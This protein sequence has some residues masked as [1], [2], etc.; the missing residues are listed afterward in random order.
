M[1]VNTRSLD[2]G[3]PDELKTKRLDPYFRQLENIL[4]DLAKNAGAGVTSVEAA[5]LSY[6]QIKFDELIS[7]LFDASPNLT[8]DCA[9]MTCDNDYLTADIA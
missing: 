5:S 6:L 4:A 8:C 7:V 1:A 9:S 3:R 2:K